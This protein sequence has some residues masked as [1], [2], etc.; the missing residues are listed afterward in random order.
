MTS[1]A[2]GPDD[3]SP[4]AGTE[5]HHLAPSECPKYVEASALMA[6]CGTGLRFGR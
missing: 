1:T 4:L 3:F 5:V 6:K 2:V